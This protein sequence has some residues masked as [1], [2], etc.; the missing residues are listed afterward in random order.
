MLRP[1]PT[2]PDSPQQNDA[3]TDA[4][5]D[6]A[7]LPAISA[8]DIQQELNKL[9]EVILGSPRVPFSG[10][11]LV[12]ED[13]LL[14]QLDAIRLNLPPAF[15]QAV[16]I[17]Q[18]RSRLMAEAERYAQDLIA[19]A[20]QQAAQILDEIG[21]VRQAEQMAQQIKNQAQQDCDSLRSQ[22]MAE[23]E[24][25]QVQSQREWDS[26]RQ[27]ALVEQKNIQQE[28]DAY[29][30]TVLSQV[31][32]QLSQMLRIIQNGRSHLQP[33]DPTPLTRPDS[34]GHRRAKAPKS[35][36]PNLPNPRYGQRSG[37]KG[38]RPPAKNPNDGQ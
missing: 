12:D 9:E 5:G 13:Q 32:Q 34:S 22:V 7:N 24:Q 2:R 36:G 8:I 6:A 1:D 23:I 37:G 27:N 38:H 18:Q 4:I 29:A 30:D 17:L 19:A 21:I 3:A 16:Q 35:S 33:A 26:L 28:A 14:D 25:M 15:R 10:R 11:T 31:E 20:E